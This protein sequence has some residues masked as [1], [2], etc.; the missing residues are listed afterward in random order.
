ML[1]YAI[2][3]GNILLHDDFP[4]HVWLHP[5]FFY[6]PSNLWEY[7]L[8]S[9]VWNQ[10]DIEWTSSTNS[11]NIWFSNFID[12]IPKKEDATQSFANDC[13]W[14]SW[15]GYVNFF[16]FIEIYNKYI[17]CVRIF[18]IARQFL[19]YVGIYIYCTLSY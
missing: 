10:Q 2:Y 16:I 14:E 1:R 3:L 13:I 15:E 19:H 4:Y 11:W 8:N 18:D 17:Q 7:Y 6:P 5:L 9:I 12:C